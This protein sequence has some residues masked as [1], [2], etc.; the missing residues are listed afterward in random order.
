M[1]RVHDA[2]PDKHAYWTEGGPDVNAPDY[3]TDW[4]RWSAQYA[5]ILKNWARCIIAWNLVLD[6]NGKPNIGPFECGG[7]VTLNSKTQELTRSGQYWAF[8]HYSKLVERGAR[9]IA[10]SGTVPGVEHVAFANPKGDTVLVLTN[11]ESAARKVS[12]RRDG[13][14]ADV[15]LPPDSVTTL[16]WS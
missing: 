10:S 11:S 16:Q 8:A 6:E 4:A 1:T 14:A 9:V 7:V 13:K 3:A 5:E 12:C 15:N 2:F